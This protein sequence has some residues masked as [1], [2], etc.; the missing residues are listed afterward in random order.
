MA[1]KIFLTWQTDVPEETNKK[2]IEEC[3]SSVVKKI[4]EIEKK[5]LFDPPFFG[6]STVENFNPIERAILNEIRSVDVF[7]A[8]LTSNEYKDAEGKKKFKMNA[9]VAYETGVFLG[10]KGD[11]LK[12]S[13]IAVNNEAWVPI[14]DSPFDFR[15]RCQIAYNR[16]VGLSGAALAS[17]TLNLKRKIRS[18]L[19]LFLSTNGVLLNS[20]STNKSDKSLFRKVLNV[21]PFNGLNA[22][23]HLGKKWIL[24]DYAFSVNENYNSVFQE[25]IEKISDESL[26][27]N[28]EAFSLAFNHIFDFGSVFWPDLEDGYICPETHRGYGDYLQAIRELEKC[29]CGIKIKM[30]DFFSEKEQKKIYKDSSMKVTKDVESFYKKNKL[31]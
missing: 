22:I 5:K 23:I 14:N 28:L 18:A 11:N 30:N 8:D 12:N 6:G 2:Y 7:I 4:N 10:L 31:T 9:N 21:L 15:G 17:C 3:V 19:Y 20:N 24:P 13:L 16:D 29:L 25:L 1:F 26:K 27:Q